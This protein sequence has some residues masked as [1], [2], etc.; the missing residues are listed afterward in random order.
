MRMKIADN[1][2]TEPMAICLLYLVISATRSMVWGSFSISSDILCASVIR[3][4]ALVSISEETLLNDSILTGASISSSS[5]TSFSS[6]A[7]L[8]F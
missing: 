8:E 4:E 5:S 7:I 2:T 1:V 6:L 3:K